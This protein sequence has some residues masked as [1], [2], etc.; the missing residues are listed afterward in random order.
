M[1]RVDGSDL[2][3]V[4]A[5]QTVEIGRKPLRPL[6]DDGT[7]RVEILDDTRSMSKRHAEFSV[8]SDGNAILRDMNSTNGTYLV[9]P[10]NDLV[11][12][13]SGSDFALT[14]D[15]V[16]LQFGDVPVDFVRFIDDSTTHSDDP[17]VAN[18]FDYALDNVASEPEASELSVDDILNLRAG[19]PTNIF[20][21]NSVRTRA[22]EL[23]EAEQQ[24]FVPFA[25]PINPVT[26]ND[27]VEEDA[28]DAAPRD[29]FA[30]A[31]DVAAGKIDEPAV[32]KEEFVPRMHDGPRHAGGRPADRLI[33]VDELGKPRLPD[34]MP[35][36]MTPQQPAIAQPAVQQDPANQQTAAQPA[37]AQEP[38]PA[39][40]AA[41]P[42]VEHDTQ[43]MV[44]RPQEQQGQE[45][46][47]FAEQSTALDFEV[48][49]TSLH[50]EHRDEPVAVDV[51]SAVAV[52][53]QSNEQQPTP[54]TTAVEQ[55]VQAEQPV[56]TVQ[57]VQ[58]AQTAQPVQTVQAQPTP[59]AADVD[60]RFKPTAQTG[61]VDQPEQ[62]QAFTPAFEPGSVFER[63]AKGEFNQREELVEAGGYNSDQAR[64]SDDFA[65]QFEMARHAE[66]LPFLAMNPALY[67]DLYA[68]LAAQGNADVDKAL[69]T[70]PGYEDYRKAM[71]K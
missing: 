37:P 58:S 10:G 27:A 23:R 43:P 25:Q 18:L 50:A 26:T 33:S 47:R 8:K 6:S 57:P 15:T 59:A 21:S 19:E 70:N 62:T 61:E 36:Q 44:Q 38:Q 1:I 54:N 71:G 65:E 9:R 3:S 68:W 20:D 40:Q 2:T 17:A 42:A 28:P 11:R 35:L 12:L 60:A 53:Q 5:G 30:D 41:A 55:S 14:D 32:K 56:Q 46:R 39:A 45:Q 29:L 24:T 31:H 34:I 51:Q 69:S 67:D 64:R 49:T 16:R 4:E 22:H 52:N 66:L 48:L 63:V 7:T 13:P